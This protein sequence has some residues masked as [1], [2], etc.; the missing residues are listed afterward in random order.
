LI[1]LWSASTKF[2]T[3][4]H[5]ARWKDIARWKGSSPYL[6]NT[7]SSKTELQHDDDDDDDNDVDDSCDDDDDD[8]NDVDDSYDDYATTQQ[9]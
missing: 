4:V 6:T 2:L 7:L 1:T 8:D 3:P 5:A 9:P